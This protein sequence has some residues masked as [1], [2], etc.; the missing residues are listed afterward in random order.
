MNM[1]EV[2][3]IPR[4]LTQADLI[5]ASRTLWKRFYLRPRIVFGYLLRLMKNPA[6]GLN[7]LKGFLAF[8]GLLLKRGEKE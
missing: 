2:V 7:L 8:I 6:I 1:L 3:F 5:K 4:G